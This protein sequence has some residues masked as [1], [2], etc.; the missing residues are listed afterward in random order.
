MSTIQ[1]NLAELYHIKAEEVQ[2]LLQTIHQ[3]R[4]AFSKANHL[5][6]TIIMAE[7]GFLADDHRSDTIESA[8]IKAHLHKQR[9][10]AELLV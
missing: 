6:E 8:T 3:L 9:Q 10:F 7:T 2:A 5:E 1:I 4:D